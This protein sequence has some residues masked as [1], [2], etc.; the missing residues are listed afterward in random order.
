MKRKSKKKALSFFSKFLLVL[1]L[2]AASFLLLSY[3][4]SYVDP[5]I[6]WPLSFFGL[7]YPWLLLLNL[8]FLVLWLF[9]NP[10]IA[11]ISAA[12]ILLGWKF[13]LNTIGFREST[14]ID[15]PKSSQNF[16]RVM[17]YN[18]HYFKKF[19]YQNDKIIKDQM[20]D[21]IRREQPDVICI[22]EFMTRK[23]G[24]Y[25]LIKSF[26]KIL[27]TNH[28]YFKANI[29]NDYEALGIAIF[30]KF[31][32]KSTGHISFPNTAKGNE[33]VYTDIEVKNKLFR[34][35]N[36]HLQSISFQP[37]DY[38]YLKK[39]TDEI[40]NVESSR[41]IGSRLKRAF[42]KRSE[43]AKLLKTHTNSCTLPYI[44]AGDFNDTPASFSVSTLSKGLKNSFYEKGS[45]FGITYNG[46]FPNFQI[47]YI[48]ATPDFNIKSYRI[49]DKKLSDHYAVRSDL[50]MKQK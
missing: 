48:L 12:C 44:I 13:I 22:Q 9:R 35:Y 18:V 41:R 32:I 27:Q 20:L 11:L 17:T 25:N 47:D 40:T 15:V 28:Y 29:D 14:A 10:R 6:F 2:I 5:R 49:I 46:D 45:G 23:K 16:L 31:P 26:K 24:E 21:V 33:A 42:L 7:G 1:N 37:E 36:V 19:D 43:Q 34:V 39:V 50:E 30:S 8:L 38:Q 4:A 3:L